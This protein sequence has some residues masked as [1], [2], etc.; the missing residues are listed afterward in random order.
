MEQRIRLM[1]EDLNIANL[2]DLTTILDK[3]S[4]ERIDRN[5]IEQYIDMLLTIRVSK[6]NDTE[7]QS[8]LEHKIDTLNIYRITLQRLNNTFSDIIL[9]K[10]QEIYSGQTVKDLHQ[11]KYKLSDLEEILGKTRQTLNNWTKSGALKS[12][13]VEG[14]AKFVLE[15]DLKAKYREIHEKELLIDDEFRNKYE[16]KI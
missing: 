13:D 10:K 1:K 2:H 14:R 5:L 6:F 3:I 11:P 7:L 8:Q 4:H 12:H 16:Y 15:S 9:K